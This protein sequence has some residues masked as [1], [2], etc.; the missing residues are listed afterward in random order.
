[1]HV[2]AP[3]CS[4]GPG[5]RANLALAALDWHGRRQGPGWLKCLAQV[6]VQSCGTCGGLA[7]EA[8]CPGLAEPKIFGTHA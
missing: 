4:P 3:G 2:T 8:G 7:V 1:M 6:A 5:A